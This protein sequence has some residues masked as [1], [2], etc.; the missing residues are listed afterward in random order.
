LGSIGTNPKNNIRKKNNTSDGNSEFETVRS[1]PTNWG[2]CILSRKMTKI[3]LEKAQQRSS[4]DWTLITEGT[5]VSLSQETL[6]L[7]KY[8]WNR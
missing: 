3:R 8:I 5:K 4:Q 7:I 6:L 1:R 2:Q